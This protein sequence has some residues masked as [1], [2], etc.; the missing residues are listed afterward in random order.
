MYIESNFK[1]NISK[2]FLIV[3]FI[4]PLIVFGQ[5]L[6]S[7]EQN[8]EEQGIE[9][10][11]VLENVDE[12]QEDSEIIIQPI[13]EPVPPPPILSKRKL[14]REITVDSEAH[15]SCMAEKFNLDIT[16]SD[17]S[18]V[19]VLLTTS[20]NDNYELEIGSLPDGIKIIFEKNN[21]YVYEPIPDEKKVSLIIK[22]EYGSNNGNFNIPIIFTKKG[23]RD[24]STICQINILNDKES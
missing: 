18:S 6:I 3:L 11:I 20:N 16:R 7:N 5:E 15:H 17:M 22:N 21:D 2:I 8:I 1:I 12:N 10:E 19:D 4:F 23:N 13:I 24:S 14:N 9:T